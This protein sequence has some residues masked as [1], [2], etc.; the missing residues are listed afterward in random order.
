MVD[1]IN[2]Q[3]PYAN[4]ALFGGSAPV[5]S[6][7]RPPAEFV[8]PPEPGPLQQLRE[9][10]ESSDIDTE[11]LAARAVE[12]FGEEGASVVNEA[13]EADLETLSRLVGEE[14]ASSARSD[15]VAR[16][17]SEAAEFV[18]EAGDFDAAGLRSFLAER[19]IEDDPTP[20]Q[21]G[22][23]GADVTGYSP[24]GAARSEA[25]PNF[26]SIVA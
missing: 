2:S 22:F 15:L 8:L 5:D 1:Q 17:G 18:S 7:Q 12:V 24:N 16:F 25:A 4:L 14:R 26:L 13:G 20:P 9:A 11:E 3:S 23:G 6:G 10:I 21:T 19:G